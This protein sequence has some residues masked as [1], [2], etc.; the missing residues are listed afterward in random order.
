MEAC[1]GGKSLK[2]DKFHFHLRRLPRISLSYKLFPVQYREY[3]YGLLNIFLRFRWNKSWN[4]L[5]KSRQSSTE[6]DIWLFISFSFCHQHEFSVFLYL[7]VT[8]K[9][10]QNLNML[11]WGWLAFI[12]FVPV[13]ISFVTRCNKGALT[14]IH[15]DSYLISIGFNFTIT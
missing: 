11:A 13:R 15:N 6:S 7:Q 9:L 5:W 2:R 8:I 14:F 3:K 4:L 10:F 1:A 12:D